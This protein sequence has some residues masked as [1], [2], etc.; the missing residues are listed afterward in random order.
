MYL[1]EFS[2]SRIAHGI[3]MTNGPVHELARMAKAREMDEMW[4]V[5]PP[6]DIQNL[7]V[8]EESVFVL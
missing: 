8:L 6:N 5:V 2:S 7:L 4:F 1:Q 3:R